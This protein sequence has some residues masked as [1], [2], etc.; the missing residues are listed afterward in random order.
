MFLGV[1]GGTNVILR[2]NHQP[3]YVRLSVSESNKQGYT[4]DFVTMTS[5][6]QNNS[7]AIYFLSPEQVQ[8]GLWRVRDLICG[9]YGLV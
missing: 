8:G 9:Q 3:L 2:Q 7:K 5:E 4:V 6:S 1:I